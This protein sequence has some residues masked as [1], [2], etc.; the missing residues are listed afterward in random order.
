MKNWIKHLLLCLLPMI[1][2]VGFFTIATAEINSTW[3]NLTW[4]LDDNGLLTIQGVGKMDSFYAMRSGAWNAF[5]S[6]IKNVIIESGVT[7]ISTDAFYNCNELLNVS[8]P[9]SVTSIGSEAF[10]FCRNITHMSIPDSVNSIGSKAFSSCRNIANI[11]IPEG[12]T[13][14]ESYAFEDCDSL[15]SMTIP[16]GVTSIGEG[17]FSSC[18]N[19]E[20]IIVPTSVTSIGNRVF[21]G[22]SPT[23]Y[24]Y[25]FSDADFW[26]TDNG[27]KV[28]YIDNLMG[29]V[30]D[31]SLPQDFKLACFAEQQLNAQVFSKIVH[32]TISW[33]SDA[34]EVVSVSADGVVKALKPGSAVITASSGEVSASVT[35]TTFT[36]A[37]DF[38][39]P[40]EALVASKGTLQIVPESISPGDAE[41]DL[42][43]TSD[44]EDVAQVNGAGLVSGRKPG[45]AVITATDSASGLARS[46]RVH[47]CYP[48][49]AIELTPTAQALH[50]DKT[51][52]L[53]A[54]VTMRDESTVNKLVTFESGNER[55]A[56]VDT[57]G[58]VTAHIPGKAVITAR[59][60]SGVSA[61]CEITV[62][63][64]L[65]LDLPESLKRIES[66]A[67]A[68]L[69]A[70]EAIRIPAGVTDIADD[71]FEGTDVILYVAKDSPAKA[72]AE[73]HGFRTIEE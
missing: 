19:L 37:K 7:S 45:D 69:A 39:L 54:N 34:P 72:W 13:N 73:A 63:E 21:L 58:L 8:I 30:W 32:P 14:I 5:K 20:K 42:T 52:Q 15:I 36:I 27:Y 26:A 22:I 68:D 6:S 16:D 10:S 29:D 71:A 47:V 1:S 61:S 57:N 33:S 28:V 59:A 64:L 17:A 38:S 11:T 4:M 50:V 23:I 48:V 51:L 66:G 65:V 12:I 18:N 44:D 25:E 62:P 9:D 24:C 67:F 49:S 60:E 56:T 70:P 2:F 53:T 55:V 40:G 31:I 43:W 41:L 46:V 35:V 3:G